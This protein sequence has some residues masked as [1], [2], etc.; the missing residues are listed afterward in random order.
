[1]LTCEPFILNSKFIFNGIN[2]VIIIIEFTTVVVGSK[3]TTK[4]LI[5]VLLACIDIGSIVN[6]DVGKD[7]TGVVNVA[8]RSNTNSVPVELLPNPG[9]KHW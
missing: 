3:D 5:N 7:G 6:I 4:G 2:F 8:E 1:M 9:S